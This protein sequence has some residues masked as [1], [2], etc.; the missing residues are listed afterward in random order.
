MSGRLVEF[1]LGGAAYPLCFTLRAVEQ[2]YQRYGDVD[3]WF[4]RL[5]ELTRQEETDPETGETRVVAEGDQM[6]LLAEVLWLLET[7]MDAGFRRAKADYMS[8]PRP[9]TLDELR[10]VVCIGDIARI[11]DAILRTV[12][13]G[14]GREVGAQAPKNGGGAEAEG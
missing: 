11:R 1:E 10:D 9:L 2:F 3:G 7:L 4:P 8:A 12:A 5:L 13:L 14:N 6:K